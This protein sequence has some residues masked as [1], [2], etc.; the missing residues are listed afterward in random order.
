MMPVTGQN[1]GR[2]HNTVCRK[3]TSEKVLITLRQPPS[4]LALQEFPKPQ[5]EVSRTFSG[6]PMWPSWAESGAVTSRKTSLV[7]RNYTI[8]AAGVIDG[9]KRNA[10]L[11]RVLQRAGE[12]L[13][14]SEQDLA[15]SVGE[16]PSFFDSRQR[17]SPV[18]RRTYQRIGLMLR[19]HDS[20]SSLVGH[21]VKHMRGWMG[22]LNRPTGGIPA[23]QLSDP[24]KLGKLVRYLERRVLQRV[25]KDLGLS[26]RALAQSVGEAPSFFDSRQRTSPIAR[27]TYQRIGLML[28]LHDSLSSLVGHDVKHMRGWMGALNRPTGGIPA[29]QLSDPEKLGKLVRYLE[30]FNF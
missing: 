23:K 3:V 25:G 9:M 13:G 19:L 7:E 12:D 22:A 24:E 10:A 5:V 14:L 26:K 1:P 16:A 8:E 30:A 27:R 20:L 21:D 6:V 15:Q 28:R 2:S 17:T 29:K 18:A 11:R 4:S